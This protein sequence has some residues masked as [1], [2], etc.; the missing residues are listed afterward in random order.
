MSNPPQH[1]SRESYLQAAVELLRPVFKTAGH[2]IPPIHVSTGWPHARGTAAKNRSLGQA[3]A[4]VA[5]ADGKCHIFISPWLGGALHIDANDCCGVLPVLAHEVVHA[6]VG[7]EA[8]HGAIFR[9][10]ALAI[11]LEGKMTSTH[12]GPKLMEH[13]KSMLP[14]LGEYP[15][16][17]LDPKLSGVKKQ[18]TRMVKCECPSCSYT[19]RT[20]RKWLELGAP[21]CPQNHGPMK[22]EMPDE[23]EGGDEGEE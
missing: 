13:L 2:E 21:R 14:L 22:F 19:V 4:N 12:A 8:K 17:K 11:G 7:I 20:T 5:S 9:K 18:G 6:V 1:L 16:A 10:L 23:D 15:H 3:W